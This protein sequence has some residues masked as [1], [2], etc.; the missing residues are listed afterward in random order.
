ML[1]S[2]EVR[3]CEYL[4]MHEQKNLRG[5]PTAFRVFAAEDL[6]NEDT[7][8]KSITLIPE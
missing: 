3:F 5:T 1:F 8:L 7:A 6:I 2:F 4:P